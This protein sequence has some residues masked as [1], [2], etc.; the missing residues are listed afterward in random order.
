MHFSALFSTALLIQVSVA[1]T[2]P[3]FVL[4]E[5]VTPTCQCNLGTNDTEYVCSDSRLG[6]VELPK[7]LIL[8]TVMSRYDRF[9]TLTPIEFIN[10]WWNVTKRKGK[11]GWNYPGNGGF[12]LD[13]R[14]VPV[15]ANLTLSVGTLV[16]RFGPEDGSYLTLAA[17]P[18]S[19]RS[20]PPD[21]LNTDQ[22]FKNFTNG[23]HVY[24]VTKEFK[25][26]AGPIAPAF[27]QP[28]LATQFWTGGPALNLTVSELLNKGHLEFIASTQL[29]IVK[30]GCG[31]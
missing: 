4:A 20:L 9:G 7:T 24:N 10:T 6:P 28:G 22:N 2:L 15:K 5:P 12:L 30:T 16:D 13:E 11:G 19:Q 25:V 27:G 18:F 17:S 31:Q 1:W 21:S 26:E 14:G 23:Y 8:G 3:Q 29:D